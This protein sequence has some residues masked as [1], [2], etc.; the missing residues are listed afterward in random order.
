MPL[1]VFIDAFLLI[2]VFILPPWFVL[3]IAIFGL[4]RFDH[5]Y[6][7]VPLALFLDVLYGLPGGFPPIPILYTLVAVFFF[8]LTLILKRHLKFYL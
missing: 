1:R 3:L 7:I 8:F 6:E 2:G 4:F 5:F